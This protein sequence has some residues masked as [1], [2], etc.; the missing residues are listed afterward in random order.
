M[1]RLNRSDEKNGKQKS[2]VAVVLFII[3]SIVVLAFVG[4]ILMFSIY[5]SFDL[6]GLMIASILFFGWLTLLIPYLN[7]KNK[8]GTITQTN[9]KESSWDKWLYCYF[10]NEKNRVS[11]AL[12]LACFVLAIVDFKNREVVPS[13]S[14]LWGGVHQKIYEL[15]GPMG[16]PLWWLT[17]GLIMTV[18]AF[19]K[20]DYK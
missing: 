12:G 16:M 9:T 13:A 3:F 6:V 11:L 7:L 19:R 15:L 10:P 18:L 2:L 14:G 20:G 8:K 1:N 4:V 5:R 17:L